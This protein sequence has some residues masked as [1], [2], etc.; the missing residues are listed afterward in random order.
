MQY[1]NFAGFLADLSFLGESLDEPLLPEVTDF[2]K[3]ASDP[4]HTGPVPLC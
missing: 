3:I 4:A 1:C 2:K